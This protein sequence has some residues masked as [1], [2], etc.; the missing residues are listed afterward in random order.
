MVNIKDLGTNMATK[1]FIIEV[2]EGWTV[3]DIC[4]FDAEQCAKLEAIDNIM[5]CATHN[6]ATMKIKEYEEV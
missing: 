6:L 5:D 4:P 1:K 3:C 2:E